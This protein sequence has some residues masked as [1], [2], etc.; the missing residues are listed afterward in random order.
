MKLPVQH[1]LKKKRKNTRTHPFFLQVL[2]HFR[3][4]HIIRQ[5]ED[6]VGHLVH[7]KARKRHGVYDQFIA[8][9]L[10]VNEKAAVKADPVIDALSERF[11][12]AG[13][14]NAVLSCV[15]RVRRVR[16]R[17]VRQIG[18]RL[19][20]GDKQEIGRASCRERVSSPV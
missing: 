14:I 16:Y 4:K 17:A 13:N 20:R 7:L 1:M 11:I 18:D 2:F 6:R 10:G 15:K 5:V 3:R 8:H 12:P 19:I 9:P